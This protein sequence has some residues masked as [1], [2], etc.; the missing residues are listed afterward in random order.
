MTGTY[1]TYV[2]EG[3]EKD[4]SGLVQT[5]RTLPE[6]L[7]ETDVVSVFGRAHDHRLTGLAFSLFVYM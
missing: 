7:G 2:L 5:R 1:K 6:S 4:L 3:F